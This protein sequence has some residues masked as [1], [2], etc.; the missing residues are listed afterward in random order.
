MLLLPFP[1]VQLLEKTRVCQHSPLH[2]FSLPILTLQSSAI[3]F[4][5]Q[6]KHG[7]GQVPEALLLQGLASAALTSL[8]PAKRPTLWTLPF[9]PKPTPPLALDNI[10]FGSPLSSKTATSQVLLMASFPLPD[11]LHVRVS[12]DSLLHLL[13]VLTY[14]FLLD[15]PHSSYHPV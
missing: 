6:P 8:C 10:F 9:F 12:W 2:S 3:R 15:T 13:V 14:H 11:S 1:S 4:S 7:T 5:P